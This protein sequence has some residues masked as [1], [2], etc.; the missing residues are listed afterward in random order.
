MAAPGVVDGQVAVY[1]GMLARERERDAASA[2]ASGS[3]A[4]GREAGIADS[5]KPATPQALAPWLGR[6]RDPWFGPVDICAAGEG[7]R[8]S[9]ARSPRLSGPVLRQGDRLLVDF[10][11]LEADADAWLDFSP[12]TPVEVA[13][14]KVDPDADF[15]YDYEDL[16]FSRVANCPM[17]DG[18]NPAP[19]M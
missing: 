16:R 5:R 14:A 11:T 8:F 19:T 15:S 7:V 17:P 2:S 9:S 13:M 4:P 3:T 18:G 6:Y 12:G 1:A 10:D